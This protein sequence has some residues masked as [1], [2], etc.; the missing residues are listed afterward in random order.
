MIERVESGLDA[1][2]QEKQFMAL[3]APLDLD[4]NMF[5]RTNAITTSCG[6]SSL[7]RLPHP[8]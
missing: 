4:F 2:T 6:L 5:K 3:V 1:L 8:S 7:E